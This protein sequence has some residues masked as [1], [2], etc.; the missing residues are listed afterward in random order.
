MHRANGAATAQRVCS[1]D[2]RAPSERCSMVLEALDGER[3][4]EWCAP[5]ARRA[6][7]AA[8]QLTRG[9]YKVALG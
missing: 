9:A 3:G 7:E 2:S 6:G 4:G 8:Q 5:E 1:V